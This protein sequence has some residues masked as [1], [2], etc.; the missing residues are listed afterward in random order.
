MSS[1][2]AISILIAIIIVVIIIGP[3]FQPS[4][5]EVESFLSKIAI[6]I[7]D[8]DYKI[9]YQ[10]AHYIRTHTACFFGKI[11]PVIPPLC[12]YTPFHYFNYIELDPNTGE[13]EYHVYLMVKTRDY[14]C[15]VYNP[16]NGKYIGTCKEL[17][18]QTRKLQ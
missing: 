7:E 6:P 16:V 11:I 2:K 3:L 15:L 18:N 4:K 12:M 17:L 10:R 8:T 13:T 1:R 14:D 5:D 9:E